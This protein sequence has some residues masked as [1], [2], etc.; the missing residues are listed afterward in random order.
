MALGVTRGCPTS[1]AL[2]SGIMQRHNLMAKTRRAQK[3]V[4]GFEEFCH[5]VTLAW[6]DLE[7]LNAVTVE[8]E[9]FVDSKFRAS[10]DQK[11]TA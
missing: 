10:H 6:I 5:V 4:A 3:Q 2:W 8:N 9:G 1:A 7:M 11:C